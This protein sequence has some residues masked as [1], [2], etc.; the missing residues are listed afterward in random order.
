MSV[1][2]LEAPE[3]QKA[4]NNFSLCMLKKMCVCT[5]TCLMFLLDGEV[6]VHLVQVEGVQLLN[7]EVS[8]VV[9]TEN[10]SVN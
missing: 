6:I 2:Y 1:R 3:T 9:F 5:L 7:C 8:A 10:V 4:L